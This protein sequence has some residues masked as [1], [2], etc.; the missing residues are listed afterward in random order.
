VRNN[1]QRVGLH[2]CWEVARC[3][4]ERFLDPAMS[5]GAKPCVSPPVL[6]SACE[7]HD[8]LVVAAFPFAGERPSQVVRFGVEPSLPEQLAVSP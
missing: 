5:F 4:C 3:S 6:D 7:T 8:G 2:A 1:A